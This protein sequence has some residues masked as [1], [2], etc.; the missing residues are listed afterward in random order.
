TERSL[1]F[2]STNAHRPR[3]EPI[4]PVSIWV[5]RSRFKY[6]LLSPLPCRSL[7]R[8]HPPLPR[9][10]VFSSGNRPEAVSGIAYCSPRS[11]ASLRIRRAIFAN[12]VRCRRAITATEK[13]GRAIHLKGSGSSLEYPNH[14]QP[15]APTGHRRRI[16]FYA[17]NEMPTSQA[18]W[19]LL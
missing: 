10:T 14:L 3:E 13:K 4:R 1:V 17:I 19:F 8:I 12:R 5:D 6:S 18:Q 7:P 11:R 16:R 15:V 2:G 9:G